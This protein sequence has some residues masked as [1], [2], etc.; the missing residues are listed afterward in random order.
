MRPP[1][2][3]A[4][5]WNSVRDDGRYGRIV[6]SV[7]CEACGDELP[8]TARRNRRYCDARCRRRAFE[9]RRRE[10]K[11]E[12]ALVVPIAEQVDLQAPDEARLVSL[13]VAEA[14]RGTWRA[15]AWLLE[16]A[17]AGIATRLAALEA[18]L[19]QGAEAGAGDV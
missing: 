19:E 11:L 17:H 9:Q 4:V 16:G 8:A 1:G 6:L 10:A 12:L 2:E 3:R 14:E 18:E 13:I 15:A 7:K 5:R